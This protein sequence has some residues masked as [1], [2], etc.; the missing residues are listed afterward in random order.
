MSYML[1]ALSGSLKGSRF[2]LNERIIIGRDPDTDVQ[3]L[4][5]GV[6]REHAAITRTSEGTLFLMDL[7]SKNGTFMGETSIGRE[8]LRPGVEF[9]IA[10]SRFR[11]VMNEESELQKDEIELQ[12]LRVASGV[13][14]EATVAN[15]MITPED[16][17][18][19]RALRKK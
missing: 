2:P 19:L 14:V 4:E 17:A 13:A 9:K 8:E 5:Y 1:E 12:E 7:S 18:K 6:S 15:G 10:E 3:L 11:V 16:L